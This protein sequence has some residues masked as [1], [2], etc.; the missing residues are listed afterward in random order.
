MLF[1]RKKKAKTQRI[2]EAAELRAK[3]PD[4]PPE[5]IEIIKSVQPYTMT[6][7]E[8]VF[9]LCN[10]VDYILQ[11]QIA[12][13]FVECGV[14]R[15]GSMAAVARTL[16]NRGVNDRSL[17][18]YDTFDGMSEPTDKDVDFLGKTA[19]HLLQAED[20]QDAKS[21]WCRS[22]I[23][24]V[25]SVMEQTSYPHQQ[26]NLVEGKVEE[27][28][29]QHRPAQIALLRLDTDWYESTRLEL[30]M[31]FPLISPGG[32][33][34]IDDF[35]HWQGCRRA[36]EEYFR[37]HQVS[38]MLNRIDYTGRIGIYYPLENKQTGEVPVEMSRVEPL[39][40]ESI[41]AT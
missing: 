12:G 11:N 5:F 38:M 37:K 15:G 17:W 33:L 4:A 25:R 29:L 19:S 18:L 9:A 35:G 31:L 39:D 14:W 40:W 28:L 41:D 16:L 30:E 8:R 23:G 22:S 3:L 10:A 1:F 26:I 32:V 27:T 7:P 20:P 13:S 24:Q 21:V 34:I 2:D 6:S 36:V